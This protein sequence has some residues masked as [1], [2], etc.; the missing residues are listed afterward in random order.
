MEQFLFLSI[1]I[2]S[3]IFG[4]LWYFL[5]HAF[6][7]GA[8]QIISKQ[9]CIVCSNFF[10]SSTW[11][12]I[13]DH[14]ILQF[15]STTHYLYSLFNPP[16]ITIT[17]QFYEIIYNEISAKIW[18][19]IDGHHHLTNWTVILL[20]KLLVIC[21]HSIFGGYSCLISAIEVVTL[22]KSSQNLGV[23]LCWVLQVPG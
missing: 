17:V 18:Q 22:Q 20:I 23:C 6:D 11:T 8:E 5:S 19:K 1:F 10:R 7:L 21:W 14:K 16:T 4:V 3:V 2:S 12:K 15:V 13:I 9:L